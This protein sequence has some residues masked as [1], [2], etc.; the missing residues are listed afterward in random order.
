MSNSGVA[1]GRDIFPVDTHVHRM[2]KFLGWVPE[3]ANENTGFFHLDMR[4]PDEFKYSLHNLFIRHGRSCKRCKGGPE[5]K[6]KNINKPKPKP[7]IKEGDLDD[8][9]YPIKVKKTKK[10]WIG[11]GLMKE[12]V[13]EI[14]TD[15]E[16]GQED[17]SCC[18]EDLV[19]RVRKPRRTAPGSKKAKEEVLDDE[20][21]GEDAKYEAMDGTH[22]E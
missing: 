11:N 12:I 15:Y 3:T 2:T 16:G 13:V 17:D 10:V 20:E 7:K 19:K 1:L 6:A 18:L 9:G 5:S 4:I 21:G 14:D 8:E 22:T